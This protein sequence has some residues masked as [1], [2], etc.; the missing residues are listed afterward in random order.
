[1]LAEEALPRPTSTVESKTAIGT[2]SRHPSSPTAILTARPRGALTS[3]S[4]SDPMAKAVVEEIDYEELPD[5]SLS[6]QLIAGALAGISEHTL[7]YPLDVIKVR[8]RDFEC[9][10][11]CT[12]M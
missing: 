11:K 7:T 5:A 3:T 4:L 6:T 2:E 9:A 12:C 10:F 1:M 8:P